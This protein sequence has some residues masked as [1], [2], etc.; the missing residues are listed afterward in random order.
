MYQRLIGRLLYLAMTRP[1]ISY[2]V[3]HLSQFMHAPMKSHYEVAIHVVRYVKKQPGVG[4]LLSSK[5]SSKVTAFCDAD[6]AFCLLSRKSVIGFGVKYE[7]YLI[8]WKS[9]K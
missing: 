9:K 4:L 1:D 2:A 3:Q 6:W 8:S 5:C 7:D